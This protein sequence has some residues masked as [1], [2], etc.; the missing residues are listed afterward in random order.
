MKTVY[1]Q[2]F[3]CQMNAADSDTI[4]DLLSSRGF[5]PCG[6]HADA[7]LVVVNTCSVREAAERRAKARIAEFAAWKKTRRGQQLWVIGCMA[8]RLGNKL[9][10]EIPG[11]DL[12]IGAKRMEAI[13]EVIEGIFPKEQSCDDNHPDLFKKTAVTDFVTIMRGCGNYCAYCVVPYVRGGERSVPYE[14][15]RATVIEKVSTGIK[16]IT[17]L[18]Q[19]VNSYNDNGT[20][21]PQLLLNLSEI[22]GL[23]RIRFTTS[24]PKDC[25][26][27]LAEAVASSPKIAKHIH[28]PAQAGSDRV[29]ALMNRRYTSAHYRRLIDMIRKRVPNADITSDIMVGF[30]GETDEE[31]RDTLSL[32]RDAR[33]TAAFMFAY[34][35]RAG[36]AAASMEELISK[37][38]KTA[39]LAELIAL[40]TEITRKIYE[41]AVGSELEILVTDRQEKRDRAWMG[42][43]LGCKRVLVSGAGIET[44]MICKV[45]AVRSSGMTLIAERVL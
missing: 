6:S 44:G 16:E 21:F 31:F 11:I 9:K 22:N 15:I 27:R 12:I 40:Q 45:R 23:A 30:P 41:K 18:G 39:R 14:E 5:A 35:P 24:H 2:T 29:L 34:S 17:L 37:E 25:T 7:D 33:F 20:D 28:L 42:T 38:E 26:E 19:N 36:T 8:E 43:D 32:V 1:F 13:E 10:E 3:G 4:R